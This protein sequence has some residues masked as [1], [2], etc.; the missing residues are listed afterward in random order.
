MMGDH[1]CSEFSFLKTM[2]HYN[3]CENMPCEQRAE[4]RRDLYLQGSENREAISGS[5]SD[6]L[7]Y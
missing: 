1:L 3:L 5:F 7:V 4:D 2:I 6:T